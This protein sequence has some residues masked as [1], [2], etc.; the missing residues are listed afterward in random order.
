MKR[1]RRAARRRDARGALR[2]WTATLLLAVFPHAGLA[3]AASVS[4]A[5]APATA[6]A[7]SPAATAPGGAT[8]ASKDEKPEKLPR[9]GDRRRA[10]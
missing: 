4:S 2:F 1:R 10:V 7:Q 6:S 9:G 3:Q 8:S 5:Q